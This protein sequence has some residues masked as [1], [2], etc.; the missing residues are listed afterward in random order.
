MKKIKLHQI[1]EKGSG[2][3]A[4]LD[5]RFRIS[6]K[7]GR[8]VSTRSGSSSIIAWWFIEDMAGKLPNAF[9]SADTLTE[10]KENIADWLE[11][12]NADNSE[13]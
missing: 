7:H 6:R 2:V 11:D 12:E 9:R 13:N 10:A 1:G 4:T 3:Y 5:N 8:V